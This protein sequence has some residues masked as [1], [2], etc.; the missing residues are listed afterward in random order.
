[1]DTTPPSIEEVLAKGAEYQQAVKLYTAQFTKKTMGTQSMGPASITFAENAKKRKDLLPE[2]VPATFNSDDFDDKMD[3]LDDMTKIE[4]LNKDT[5]DSMK[6]ALKICK[7]DGKS[8]ANAFY[9]YLKSVKGTSPKYQT[10]L[11]ELTPFHS[12]SAA[13]K[14]PVEPTDPPKTDKA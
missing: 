13:E 4:K 9:G 12:K 6:E 7:T 3:A 1:M 2:I 5:T 14:E 10:A 11:D 8:Y